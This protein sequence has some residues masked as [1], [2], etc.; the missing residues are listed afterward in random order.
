[1]SRLV[2]PILGG[3]VMISGIFARG[4]LRRLAARISAGKAKVTVDVKE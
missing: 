2:E 4:E 3:E 1:M